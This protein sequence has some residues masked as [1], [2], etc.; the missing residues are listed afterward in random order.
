MT[1]YGEPQVFRFGEGERLGYTL[2]Q[3]IATSCITAHFSE[4]HN[5]FYL[6]VFSCKAFDKKVVDDTIMEFFRPK[7]I[8]HEHISRNAPQI[9]Q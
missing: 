9:L 2:I 1:K 4:E 8:D 7:K 5:D 3:P 6:D